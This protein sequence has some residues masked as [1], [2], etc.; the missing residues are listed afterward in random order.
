MSARQRRPAVN[1]EKLPDEQLLRMRVRDLALRIEGSPLAGRIDRLYA[2][3]AGRGIVFRPPCYL[4]DEW[5]CPDKVPVIGVPFFLA[6]PRL[7]KLENKMMLEAEGGTDAACMKLLRHEAGH[8]VNYAYEL[9]R[10]TRWRELFG[11]FSDKYSDTYDPLPY[12]KRYVTHLPDHYAQAHPDEDFAETFA[13]WLSSGEG[14]RTKYRGWPAL[15]KLRYV[16]SLMARIGPTP[17]TVTTRETPY[18][19]ARMTRTL[20]AYY[21]RK[22]AGMGED[23]PGY[24]DPGLVRLFARAPAGSGEPAA[25]FI[26][27]NRRAIVDGV[28]AWT[29][30]R[31][32]DIDR[33]LRKLIRRC[34]ALDLVVAR[35]EAETAFEIGAFVTAV[36]KNV[37]R[38]R[39]DAA[40]S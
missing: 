8:A 6:H 3:L 37:H 28:A 4:A 26:R 15:R 35:G 38:F 19:A 32:F 30:E 14:W 16:D 22:R 23:F 39:E 1:W 11:R 33:L 40:D 5:F 13:V 17:P 7:T 25:A 27:R 29:G 2:E 24:Y 31:K 36:M 12:S 20:A 10:R 21:E 34:R 9:F 18:S